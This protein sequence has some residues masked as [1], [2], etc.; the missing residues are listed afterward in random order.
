MK[1]RARKKI[2]IGCALGSIEFNKIF[3]VL[4]IS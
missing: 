3:N 1:L 2:L 4:N